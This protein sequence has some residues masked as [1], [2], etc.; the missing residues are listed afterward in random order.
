[1]HIVSFFFFSFL[2]SFQFFFNQK[3][4]LFKFVFNLISCNTRNISY[5][6]G[7]RKPG[8]EIALTAWLKIKSQSQVLRYG[9]SIFCLPHRPRISDFFCYMPSLGV[10]S[11]CLQLHNLIILWLYG[12]VPLGHFTYYVLEILAYFIIRFYHM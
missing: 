3:I 1:M 5:N 11:L 12:R 9:Q 7:Q 4:S 10:C 8:E 6:D 2:L